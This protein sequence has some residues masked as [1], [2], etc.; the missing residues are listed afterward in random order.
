MI[1]AQ[2]AFEER[3]QFGVLIA[4]GARAACLT[5]PVREAATGQQG[6]CVVRADHP[7]EQ[8]D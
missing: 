3:E 8:S 6:E 2:E 5:G 7:A 1:A 4:G